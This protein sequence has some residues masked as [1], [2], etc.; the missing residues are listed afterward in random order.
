MPDDE[1]IHASVCEHGGGW[2]ET[3]C[4]DFEKGLSDAELD[5]EIEYLQMIADINEQIWMRNKNRLVK[6]ETARIIKEL[7]Y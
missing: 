3:A 6:W 4:P 7:I 1:C 5:A 2:C